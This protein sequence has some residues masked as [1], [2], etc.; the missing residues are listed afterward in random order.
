MIELDTDNQANI[1]DSVVYCKNKRFFERTIS[2]SPCILHIS[3]DPNRDKD[4]FQPTEVDSLSLQLDIQMRG[5]DYHLGDV[6]FTN[7]DNFHSISLD[8]ISHGG[9]NVFYDGIK[10]GNCYTNL[11][12]LWVH[13]NMLWEAVTS[14]NFVTSDRNLKR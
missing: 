9:V 4:L 14:V 3:C 12:L 10:R 13:T 2:H 8:P 11:F 5:D 7:R 6:I 1:I